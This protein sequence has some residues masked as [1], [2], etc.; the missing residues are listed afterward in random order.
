METKDIILELRTK[1]GL[2]QDELAEKVFVTR[3][4]VSR[5]E[6]GETIPNTETLKLLFVKVSVTIK[7]SKV[8][9]RLTSIK[10]QLN[11]AAVSLVVQF[12]LQVKSLSGFITSSEPVMP[13][14]PSVK[15]TP[16]FWIARAMKI[17]RIFYRA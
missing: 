1:K 17:Q 16:C 13:I 5:L 3:Q 15:I 8:A 4:A 9:M 6:N 2:S 14:A 10:K 11:C 7:L 12:F